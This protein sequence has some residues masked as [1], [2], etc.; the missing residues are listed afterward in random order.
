MRP[1][2]RAWRCVDVKPRKSSADRGTRS[3]PSIA[4][5]TAVVLEGSSPAE[6][7]ADEAGSDARE[8]EHVGEFVRTRCSRR[9]APR[10]CRCGGSA[11]SFASRMVSA[12]S[13]GNRSASSSTRSFAVAVAL[14]RLSIGS[15]RRAWPGT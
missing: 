13:L 14:A 5:A 8:G 1:S 12:G 7:A 11:T 4:A 15:A 10:G 9:R 2:P 6:A 3:A